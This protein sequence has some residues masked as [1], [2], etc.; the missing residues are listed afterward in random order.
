MRITSNA[1]PSMNARHKFHVTAASDGD[2][3]VLRRGRRKGCA[4]GDWVGLG[5]QLWVKAGSE[6]VSGPM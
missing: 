2:V 4:L 1:I 6:A 3:S 5:P